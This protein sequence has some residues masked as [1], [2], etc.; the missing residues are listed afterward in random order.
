[1]KRVEHQHAKKGG[2]IGKTILLSVLGFFVGIPTL[3][4]CLTWIGKKG[5]A[6]VFLLGCTFLGFWIYKN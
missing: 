2:S 4:L 1:M 3:L 5:L 6:I